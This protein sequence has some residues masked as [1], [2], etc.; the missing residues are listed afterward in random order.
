VPVAVFSLGGGSLG[1]GEEER[2]LERYSIK[3]M[4]NAKLTPSRAGKIG[5]SKICCMA[6]GPYL[7]VTAYKSY[8]M[9][10][11]IFQAEEMPFYYLP[12]SGE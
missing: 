5:V 2:C 7:N 1:G 6:A 4:I 8:T 12:R 10:E 9:R 11:V 3:A